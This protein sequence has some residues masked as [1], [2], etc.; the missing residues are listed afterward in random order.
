M[1]KRQGVGSSPGPDTLKLRGYSIVRNC[2]SENYGGAA[3]YAFL[4]DHAKLTHNTADSFGGGGCFV[5]AYDSSEICYN[6][7]R[8]GGAVGYSSGGYFYCN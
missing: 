8:Y 1:Y 4:F 6:T 2:H 3:V 5:W 7:S